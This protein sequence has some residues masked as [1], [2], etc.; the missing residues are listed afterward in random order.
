M[1]AALE[2]RQPDRVPI[3]MNFQGEVFERLKARLGVDDRGA[4]TWVGQDFAGVGARF[5]K[6]V[7]EVRYADPTIRVSEKGHL[8]DLW[9][10]PFR[11]VKTEYQSYVEL[12]GEPPL[13]T[14]ESVDELEAYPWPK[15]DDWDYSGIGEELEAKSEQATGGH[16]RGFFEIAHFMRGMEGFLTDLA[17]RPELA[18]ALMDHISEFLLE[19][20]RRTLE[21]GEGQYVL[22]EYNDDVASQRG[23]FMSPGM[24]R[25]HVK[26]RMAKFCDLIHAHGAK[27]RYHCCGSPYAILTDL[28]EI[29]VDILHPV[30]PLATDM[31]PFRLK[32]EFGD[33]LTFHGAIDTQQLLPH[34]S[35]EEVRREGRR[36]IDVVGK[37]GGY[38]LAGSHSIQGDVP[39][40]NV[41]AMIE[42]AHRS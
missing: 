35:V 8:V 3:G 19:K 21:A 13:G 41:V 25:E 26:P 5:T 14:L 7:S 40:D 30:Q 27:V 22:F 23:L 37:N 18:C 4:W 6:A 39:L 29:G 32:E 15:A 28:V 34:G 31:D 2:H 36:M 20:T 38:V 12:V 42:E 33:R 24:W 16:S 9:G 11:Q 10:V 17:L 1:L